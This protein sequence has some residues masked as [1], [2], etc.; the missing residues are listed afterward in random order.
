M[1]VRV[2]DGTGVVS[3]LPAVSRGQ[4]VDLP[5]LEHVLKGKHGAE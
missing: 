5:N 2:P 4:D 1:R 3:D